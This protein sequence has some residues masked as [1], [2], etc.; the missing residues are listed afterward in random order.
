M[1][2]VSE[3]AKQ[4]GIAPHTVRYYIRSGLLTPGKTQENNYRLFSTQAVQQVKFVYQAKRLG[5]AQKEILQV[6]KAGQ[7]VKTSSDDFG[8]MIDHLLAERIRIMDDE[9]RGM[10]QLR[11]K[12]QLAL[13][14]CQDMAGQSSSEDSVKCLME[15]IA[16][17]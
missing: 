4:S 8:S 5:L 13:E 11:D 17:I 12:A 3:L 10:Q 15:A 16:N 1:L 14:Q 6:L 9:I 7:N 2:T